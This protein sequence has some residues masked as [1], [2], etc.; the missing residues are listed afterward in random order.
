[1]KVSWVT[2]VLRIDRFIQDSEAFCLVSRVKLRNP[3]LK[4]RR[5]HVKDIVK[6][7]S[8]K[9]S[10]WPSKLLKQ[11]IESMFKIMYHS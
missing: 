9:K 5:L 10:D 4:V 1:M 8:L 11:R 2:Y 3:R 6:S 7:V